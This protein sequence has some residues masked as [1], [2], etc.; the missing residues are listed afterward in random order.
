VA[1]LE[2][3]VSNLIDHAAFTAALRSSG[4]ATQ[5]GVEHCLPSGFRIERFLA[6]VERALLQA[7]LNEHPSR[8][9]A[10]EA[11]LMPVETFSL[12]LRQHGVALPRAARPTSNGEPSLVWCSC[13]AAPPEVTRAC[14][15]AG[16]NVRQ[17]PPGT[18]HPKTLSCGT[19]IG[20][21]VDLSEAAGG[22]DAWLLQRNPSSSGV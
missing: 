7:A 20:A 19:A 15:T 6:E 1:D 3:L 22:V 2:P 8:T 21:V 13:S 9:S 10:A 16:L 11:T 12:H 4:A 18:L 17:M 5:E 14:E